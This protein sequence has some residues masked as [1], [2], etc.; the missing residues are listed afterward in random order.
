MPFDLCHQCPMIRFLNVL[1]TQNF[2]MSHSN[3]SSTGIICQ[4]VRRATFDAIHS[5][6]AVRRLQ[7]WLAAPWIRRHLLNSKQDLKLL[8]L[9]N[10]LDTGGAQP[11]D[12][13]KK[14]KKS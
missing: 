6:L 9:K 14:F 3:T 10:Q 11:S 4:P 7:P 12:Q 5:F 2:G 13:M 8:G 1:E